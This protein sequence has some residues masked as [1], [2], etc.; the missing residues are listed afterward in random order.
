MDTLEICKMSA[1]E[2]RDAI[3]GKELS[4]VEIVDAILQRIEKINPMINAYCTV[5]ADSARQEAKIAEKKVMQ[6][7]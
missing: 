4:P 2:M 5:V 7:V 3:R 6:G 1:L